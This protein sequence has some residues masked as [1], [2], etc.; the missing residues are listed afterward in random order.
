MAAVILILGLVAFAVF[1]LSRQVEKLERLVE[2]ASNEEG[3]PP[4]DGDYVFL[5]TETTGLDDDAEI[6]EIA[7]V[8]VQGKTLLDSLVKP[9]K[10]M[11]PDN[12]AIWIHGITNEILADAPT[13]PEMYPKL[14]QVVTG[15]TII[16]YNAKYDLRL[17]EQTCRR[18]G[19]KNSIRQALCLML[20]YAKWFGEINKRTQ[21]YRWHSLSS[22][23]CVIGYREYADQHR[24]RS[25]CLAALSVWHA[26]QK[27]ASPESLLA[28]KAAET[29][30]KYIEQN[31]QFIA[32]IKEIINDG[33]LFFSINRDGMIR[34][35]QI[36]HIIVADEHRIIIDTFIKPHRKHSKNTAFLKELCMMP[37]DFD[38]FPTWPDTYQ[39]IK[40][41][42][43]GK[44]ILVYQQNNIT[45][46]IR[47][48][49]K[50]QLDAIDCTFVGLSGLSTKWK[51]RHYYYDWQQAAAD[52]TGEPMSG[53]FELS[54]VPRVLRAMCN[55]GMQKI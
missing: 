21:D 20:L 11:A 2:D 12:D 8:D 4:S 5:D 30:A 19:I 18:Y 32:E 6:I 52:L 9:S 15:K 35:S 37:E 44:H 1:S 22:A 38:R 48:N 40:K 31:N 41:L 27:Y 53:R 3:I 39:I 23:A 13:W 34:S 51:N 17:I 55:T 26:L 29:Y 16:I 25:D 54:G 10:P 7:V 28:E 33:C 45:K 36:V 49:N 14:Q 50:F 43:T 47:E 46:L 24:A 42:F